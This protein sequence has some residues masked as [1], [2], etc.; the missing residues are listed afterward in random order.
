MIPE[1]SVTDGTTVVILTR[2]F[3][4]DSAPIIEKELQPVILQHPER[5]LFDFSK[6]DYVSSAGL[7]MLLKLTRAIRD[8]GGTSALTSLNR[9]TTY[10]FEI[11]GFTKIFTI[12]PT[13]DKALRHMR[14][15][16]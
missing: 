13:R 10:V 9:Q 4:V 7:R 12:Y 16:D 1:I 15:G 6:T 2:R 8:G 11:A 5:V 14:K 3:D